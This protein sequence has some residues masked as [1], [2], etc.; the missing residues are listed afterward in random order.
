MADL[1]PLAEAQARLIALSQP[2]PPISVPTGG[3]SGRILAETLFANRTQPAADLSAMDGYAICGAPPWRLAG[4]ARAGAPMEAALSPGECA[5]ISTGAHM[6]TGSDRVLIQENAHIRGETVECAPGASFPEPRRHVRSA[7][8]DFSAGDAIL[9]AGYPLSP[10]AIALA[11]GAGHEKVSVHSPPS[12]AVLD[13]GDELTEHV[14]DCGAGQIPAS[15]GPMIASML[16]PWVGQTQLLG[17]QPDDREALAQALERADC[18]LLIT[19]GGASVGDHDLTRDALADWGAAIDFWK[20]AIKPGKPM[21]VA[22]RRS[23]EGQQV[24]LGLPGNPVSAFVTAFLF[25]LPLVRAMCGASEPFPRSQL[26]PLAE[27]LPQAGTRREFLRAIDDGSAVRLAQTQDSGA[28]KALASAT[29]LIERE[30]GAVPVR[31]GQAVPVYNLHNG[32]IMG[33]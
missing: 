7:G 30:P 2:M 5:R 14:A 3:A 13:C 17:P 11:L 25:A 24:I 19:T 15:N 20:V 31:A 12:V 23:A 28:L 27:D 26:R 29:C 22:T 6:P 16:A 10:A 1:L 9:Q 8:F 18:D 21:L 32:G 4:E 33:F